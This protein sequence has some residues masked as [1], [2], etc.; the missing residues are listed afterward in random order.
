MENRCATILI[1]LYE[2]KTKW[3]TPLPLSPLSDSIPMGHLPNHHGSIVVL[4]STGW[5]P[6]F[7]Q[8]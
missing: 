7:L 1:P 3:T 4:A 2:I 6:D 5:V 8:A